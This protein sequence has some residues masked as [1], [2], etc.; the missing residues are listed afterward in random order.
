MKQKR[1]LLGR[2]AA[3]ILDEGPAYYEA[4]GK[5]IWTL[6]GFEEERDPATEVAALES[7]NKEQVAG[8]EALAREGDWR[9]TA[10][11]T[12]RKALVAAITEAFAL[13]GKDE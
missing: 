13:G 9:L 11:Q 8:A 7:R 4:G 6:A 10:L 1:R 3:S 5:L 12:A 2:E